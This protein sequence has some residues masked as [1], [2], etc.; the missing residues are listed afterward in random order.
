MVT[1]LNMTLIKGTTCI[2]NWNR[3]SSL[4]APANNALV[5]LTL[6]TFGS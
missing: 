2:Y 4:I 6:L 5:C 1:K 3:L